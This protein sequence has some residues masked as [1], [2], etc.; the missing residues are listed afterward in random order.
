[1]D[2]LLFQAMED[3]IISGINVTIHLAEIPE[4]MDEST[5][6]LES[7]SALTS[8][9]PGVRLR[10]GHGTFLSEKAKDI[11]KEL[12]IPIEVCLT[13]NI[14]CKTV[15]EYSDHHVHE[16]FESNHPFSLCTDDLGVF[17]NRLSGSLF[18]F[19]N[20]LDEYFILGQMKNLDLERLYEIS[21]QTIN[22]I[23]GD[24]YVKS[25]LRKRFELFYNE[26]QLGHNS[27]NAQ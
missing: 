8:K 22:H 20:R 1:M 14:K 12:L 21:Y 9:N 15:L 7:Y 11:A 18:H 2:N 27:Q 19:I 13:S 24:D 3:C 25:E 16:L 23:F 5:A 10:I 26:N 6:M 17:G 4:S